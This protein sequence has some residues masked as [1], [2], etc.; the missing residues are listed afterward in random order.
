MVLLPPYSGSGI[1]A[2]YPPIQRMSKFCAAH[3]ALN[4]MST[5][6]HR[7]ANTAMLRHLNEDICMR[8]GII[9]RSTANL[10]PP[11]LPSGFSKV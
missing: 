11:M 1:V 9:H 8:S 4:I 3:E 6:A 7:I 2:G 5:V 10:P